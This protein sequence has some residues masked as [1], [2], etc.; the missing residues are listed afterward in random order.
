M[1]PQEFDWQGHE[2]EVLQAVLASLAQLRARGE[3]VIAD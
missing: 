2:P 1:P 3:D